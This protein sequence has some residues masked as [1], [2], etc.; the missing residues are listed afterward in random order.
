MQS[1]I[2]TLGYNTERARRQGQIQGYLYGLCSYRD[3]SSAN[4]KTQYNESTL[5]Y[6][7]MEKGAAAT[8]SIW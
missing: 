1:R 8:D 6:W 3:A 2:L 5:S 4:D 7:E